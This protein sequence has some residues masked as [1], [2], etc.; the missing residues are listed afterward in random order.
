MDIVPLDGD[1]IHVIVPRLGHQAVGIKAPYIPYL[2]ILDGYISFIVLLYGI[3]HPVVSSHGKPDECIIVISV[4]DDVLENKM[5][6]SGYSDDCRMVAAVVACGGDDG[7][8]S[9]SP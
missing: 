5:L 8:S 1:I 3:I 9:R 6:S 2:A 7:F 4:N